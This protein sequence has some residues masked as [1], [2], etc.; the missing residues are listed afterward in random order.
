[1]YINSHTLVNWFCILMMF[2]LEVEYKYYK[3]GREKPMRMFVSADICAT[4][5]DHVLLLYDRN[6]YEQGNLLQPVEVAA[7]NISMESA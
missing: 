2:K 3:A 4:V 6:P 1:M 7:E 5:V